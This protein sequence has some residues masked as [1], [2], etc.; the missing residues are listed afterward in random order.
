MITVAPD[1]QALL[2]NADGQTPVIDINI[3]MGDGVY[4]EIKTLEQWQGGNEPLAYVQVIPSINIG[5][6]HVP[7]RYQWMTSDV[8]IDATRIAGQLTLATGTTHAVA[9]PPTVY[10]QSSSSVYSVDVLHTWKDLSIAQ[11]AGNTI[12]Q[13]TKKAI[14]QTVQ[15]TK[16]IVKQTKSVIN[17][18][19]SFF[20]F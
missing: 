5:F 20:G 15:A 8:N 11:Q 14:G 13:A 19:A 16:K 6:I 7:A 9:A 3:P 2:T 10:G 12:A 4:G 17:S 1:M 18:V